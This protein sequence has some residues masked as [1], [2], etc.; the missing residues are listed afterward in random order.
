MN[1]EKV[2]G[3]RWGDGRVGIRGGAG[4][5]IEGPG[6]DQGPSHFSLCDCSITYGMRIKSRRAGAQ[7]RRSGH[8]PPF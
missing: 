6:K 1:L 4:M 3:L 7:A 8:S 2:K 5:Q